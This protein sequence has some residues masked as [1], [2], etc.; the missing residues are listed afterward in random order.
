MQTK[1]TVTRAAVEQW[2]AHAETPQWKKDYNRRY[3]QKHKDYWREYYGSTPSYIHQH[4]AETRKDFTDYEKSLGDEYDRE[5]SNPLSDVHKPKMQMQIAVNRK[6]WLDKANK[7]FEKD[8]ADASKQFKKSYKELMNSN[9]DRVTKA[10][11]T[12]AYGKLKA[13]LVLEKAN[14][15]LTQLKSAIKGLG[16][17]PFK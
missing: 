13:A 3:Y 17:N 12:I 5:Y 15:K 14:W 7:D 10:S 9:Y 4:G 6:I 11:G 2:L 8:Y 1:N 16:K